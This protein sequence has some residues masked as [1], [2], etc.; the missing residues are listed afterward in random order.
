MRLKL[1]VDLAGGSTDVLVTADPHAPIGAIAARL[2]ERASSCPAEPTL[3]VGRGSGRERLIDARTELGESGLRSGDRVAIA[4]SGEASTRPSAPAATLQVV[5]GPGAPVEHS[6]RSGTSFVG[7][8]RSADVRLVDPLVSKRHAKINVSELVEIIDD[9]SANGIVIGGQ[10]VD[11]AVLRPGASVTLG[12][13]TFTVTLHTTASAND[14]GGSI[15]FNR[16]PRLDPQYEGI[17]L[18]APEPPKPPQPQRF[19]L[20]MLFAPIMMAGMIYAITRSATAILFVALSPMMMIGGYIENRRSG[21]KALEEGTARF[22]SALVDLSVQLG[23]AADREREG[24]RSEHP[25][26]AEIEAAVRDL[27][28]LA[29]TRRPEHDAFLTF[30]IGL[31]TRPS[32]NGVELPTSNETLPELWTE[33]LDVVSQFS[34]VARVPVVADLR[35]AGNVGVAGPMDRSAELMANLLGQLVGV[36]A[37]SE[38]VLAAVAGESA[39]RWDWLKWL[40][41]VGSEFS[42]LECS[43]LA[44]NSADANL[45]VSAIEELVD[46]RSGE[47]GESGGTDG[48]MLPAIILL[49]SDDA[50]IER[51]RLVQLAERGPAVSVHLAWHASS[52][53]RLPA[54]CRLFAEV[55]PATGEGRAGYVRGGVAVDDLEPE[56]VDLETAALLARRLSPVYD[57]GSRTDDQSDLPRSV[58]FLALAGPDLGDDASAVVESWRANNA[59]PLSPSAPRRDRDNTLRALVGQSAV[60]P[61]H[62]DLRTQGPHAL[63]GGTTGSG[64]SEFLQSWVLGMA[65]MH[66]PSRVTFLFVDYKGGAAFADCVDLPHCVGLVT[67]LS[68][69]LVRRALASLNA[70]LHQR[71]IL[72]NSK[73]AKDLLELERANDPDAPPSL[74]IVI[75]EF[76]A[77]VNEVP[78]F[79]DGVVNVAQ[80]GR[81]LGLHL[82]LA[83]QRPAGVIRDN[84]RANTNL[85]VALRMADEDDSSDVVGTPLAATFDP[86]LPGR[87]I[88][89]SGP[90]RLVTFQSAYVGGHTAAEAPRPAVELRDLSFGS[91]AIWDRTDEPMRLSD[92]GPP[93]ISRIVWA[94]GQANAQV[95]IPAP[96]RP[97]LPELAPA[98]RLD[99]LPTRRTDVELVYG[100]LDDPRAQ[101]QPEIAFRPD[102]DGNMAVYGTGGTGKSTFLRSIAIAA[103]LAPARGGPCHV[104]G[105]DFGSRGLQMLEDLPHVG[106]VIGGDDGERVQRLIRT[107]RAAVDERAERYA[108][109]NAATIVEYRELAGRPDEPRIVVLV[110]GVGSFRTAYEA[111]NLNAYW[112][113]FQ[114]VAADGRSVG[115]HVIV[116]ADRPAAVSSGLASSIQRRLVL[117]LANEMDYL[118]VDTPSDGFTATSPPG[119]GFVDGAEV[120]VAVIGGEANVGRQA[121]EVAKL[122]AAMRREGIEQAP[123]IGS[124]PELVA[125]SDLPTD[126]DGRPTIG[127]WDETLGPIGL[128]ES[129]PFVVTG[130]P[131]SG[132]TTAV[133]TLARA[134]RAVAPDV[135]L[136]HLGQPRS[137]LAGVTGWDHVAI[138]AGAIAEQSAELLDK[139]RGSSPGTWVVVVEAVGELLNSECDLP[140]QDL[141]KACRASEQYV[142]AEGE[143]STLSGSWP[144]LQ[145]VKVSRTGIVLQPDQMDGDAIFKTSFPRVARGDFPPGRGLLVT[146][147]KAR[148]VQ[149]AL[150]E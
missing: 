89:K 83:T 33:L 141:L 109:V 77:L 11:R 94:V 3:V 133:A 69:H 111:T 42:P 54:A 125:A 50:P 136:V 65:A 4:A 18:K 14:E 147:G 131:A 86:A 126:V 132:R 24:R 16:S 90:G 30:R 72:L 95:G 53:S 81:S 45:L 61:M 26:A 101:T 5:A 129:S 103:A 98:Y 27:S 116:S 110:D 114:N 55:D 145:V 15:A 113:M 150:P 49:V 44:A 34:Q 22:R 107:L 35:E 59:L 118:M 13:T 67:D 128:P 146:A 21:K 122:A 91:G 39:A 32:R 104:Y 75:D 66:S 88:A 63:V 25:S 43:H 68:Q 47:R 76:A 46:E 64:K 142:I 60:G 56:R 73:K 1:T 106:A 105:L 123:G 97:W 79:V 124:L 58:S 17:S 93:D 120:Q 144:L 82:V 29:W 20:V 78:E 7:R 112:E 143:T 149:V 28:E 87:G 52:V 119:R 130:P 62:L 38:L 74:V 139:V 84:L 23:Y 71:E 40:P 102:V 99:H 100:V 92:S 134:I 31:G 148:R 138:G 135:Q 36:H 10:V 6:L 8:D 2:A 137:P 140:L 51:A 9:G 115:L 80:R 57:S 70:E 117:R 19:P 127:V 41:H 48:L 121:A 108:Q 37:P 12:D 96:R 85:R